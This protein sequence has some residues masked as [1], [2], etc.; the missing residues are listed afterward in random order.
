MSLE[1]KCVNAFIFGN[2]PYAE[3]LL[4]Q[5]TQQADIRTI[6]YFFCE[7]S[8][9]HLAARHGWMDIIIDLITKYKCNTNCKDSNG[10]TP[11][12]YAAINNHLKVVRYFIN[13]H[14]YDPMTRDNDG[15]TPLHVACDN[16]H[17]NITKYLISEAHCNPSCENKNGDTP[18]H[19]TCHYGCF[20]I[21]KYLISEAHCNPSC[22][23]KNGDTPLHLACHY[24]C[25]DITKYLISEAHCNPSCENKN[26]DT[27]LCLAFNRHAHIVQYLLSNG[28][29]NQLPK[30]I[31]DK[32]PILKLSHLRRLPM[33]HLAAHYGWM[34]YIIDQITIKSVTPTVRTLMDALH[35]TMLPSTITRRW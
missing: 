17:L 27:P 16:G 30:N 7:V 9:L 29:L 8:L 24:G 3:R 28:K 15:D 14:Y 20:D 22:E 18:L 25:F 2:K 13:E 26:G 11:L 31:S 32:T 1:S 5:I 21:T 23:N 10:C 33:L 34:E 35:Y 12:H 6:I 19:L 4:P